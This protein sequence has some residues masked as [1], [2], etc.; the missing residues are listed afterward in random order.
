MENHLS[1]LVSRHVAETQHVISAML[2]DQHLLS[3]VQAAAEIC[4]ECIRRGGKLLLAGNG[5]SAA[6]AQH[7]AGEF[8]GKFALTRAG[9]PAMALTTDTSVLTAI[10]NDYGTGEIFAR[11][12]QAL[13][14]PGDVFI[15]LSTSGKSP[16][17]LRALEEAKSLGLTCVGFTGNLGGPM[18][19]SC[20]HIIEVP[21]S[22]TPR[23]Q[24]GHLILGHILCSLV[25]EAI[26]G[27][28]A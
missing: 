4:I 12:L 7:F 10:G 25:E 1:A 24:E 17:I 23:I 13:G 22:E 28:H 16:N 15:A 18:K 20:D 14:K 26:F 27:I 9:L 21:S 3:A 6:E 19:D 11:Q 5:G 2:V 8:V